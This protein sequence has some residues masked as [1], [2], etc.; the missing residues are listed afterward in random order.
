MHK[1]KEEKNSLDS[2]NLK[3]IFKIIIN[4][5]NNNNKNG[6]IFPNRENNP[7]QKVRN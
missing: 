4:F 2:L 6:N 5:I 3:N 7:L 1:K